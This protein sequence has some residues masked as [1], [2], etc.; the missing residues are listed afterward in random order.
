MMNLRTDK[1]VFCLNLTK[2]DTDENK[3]IYSS[4][5]AI[6]VETYRYFVDV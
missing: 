6:I 4:F 5:E 3:A 2:M 1:M